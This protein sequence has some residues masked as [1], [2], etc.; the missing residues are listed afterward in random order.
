MR[1]EHGTPEQAVTIASGLGDYFTEDALAQIASPSSNILIA[2]DKEQ[3]LGFLIYVVHR[4]RAEIVWMGIRL[5]K[6]RQGIG[7]FLVVHLESILRKEG[8]E[9]LM[10]RTLDD[11][12]GYDPYF[13]TNSF[14]RA[15]GFI[16]KGTEDAKG[17]DPGNLSSIYEKQMY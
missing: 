17:W 6:Q 5:D 12:V 2:K 14:Y 10:V 3:V 7:T 13:G 1:I 8:V 11:S 15:R 4:E 9:V 16:K